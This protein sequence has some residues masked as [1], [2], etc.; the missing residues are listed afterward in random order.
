MAR[1][2]VRALVGG[3]HAMTGLSLVQGEVYE[4]EEVLAGGKIFERVLT[5]DN[6]TP[7]PSFPVGGGGLSEEE[8]G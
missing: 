7:T 8:E 5:E 4:I 1:I 6:I 2:K 3:V